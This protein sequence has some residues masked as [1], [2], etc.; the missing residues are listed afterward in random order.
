METNEIKQAMFVNGV[1]RNFAKLFSHFFL[2]ADKD[3]SFGRYSAMALTTAQK[4]PL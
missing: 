4:F 1:G 2:F 3:D